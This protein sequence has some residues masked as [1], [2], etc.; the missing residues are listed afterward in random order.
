M[1]KVLHVDQKQSSLTL[2][3]GGQAKKSKYYYYRTFMKAFVGGKKKL[4]ASSYLNCDQ[5]NK[6][7]FAFS[8]SSS[9]TTKTLLHHG[10]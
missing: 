9:T 2:F 7:S 6:K 8:A 4:I 1:T 3:P 10:L 5:L